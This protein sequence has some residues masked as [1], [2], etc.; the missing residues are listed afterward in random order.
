MDSRQKRIAK[1]YWF[2]GMTPKQIQRK[3]GYT[4]AGV[5]RACREYPQSY[6]LEQ[7]RKRFRSVDIIHRKLKELAE[8]EDFRTIERVAILLS[9]K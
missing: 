4:I 9:R 2:T 7:R 6:F 8:N 1:D 5:R 3:H